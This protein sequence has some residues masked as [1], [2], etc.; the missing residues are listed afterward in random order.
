MK[1]IVTVSLM[2]GLGNQMFQIASTYSYGKKWK[3]DAKFD[4][5]NCY[6]PLQGNPST[7]YSDN[8]FKN[9]QKFEDNEQV[10]GKTYRYNENNEKYKEIPF[11]DGNVI[12]QGYFQNQKYFLGFDEDIKNLFSFSE[13]SNLKVFDFLS[14]LPEDKNITSIHIRRG[15]Y[16]KFPLVHPICGLDYYNQ[17]IKF[18]ENS[19][20]VVVS[21][22]IYWC[23]ENLKADNIFYSP[24]T[25]EIDDLNLL[26]N[27]NNNII[28]N[29]TFSW[30]GAFLNKN[31]NKKVISPK[32]WF[33]KDGPVYG[34][35]IVIDKWIK[36]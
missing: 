35:D 5:K 2:G 7:K 11:F 17:S 27:C 14:T 21:D 36:I 3:F 6:T 10:F 13:E 33:G 16:L 19:I 26:K 32:I 1:N 23:K 20:F 22:D 24:F 30:W 28:A 8:F 29:S 9:L 31:E 18:F 15:D 25:N 12:L 34:E 4:L